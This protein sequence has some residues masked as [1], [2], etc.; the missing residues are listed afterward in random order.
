MTGY[1]ALKIIIIVVAIAIRYGIK[2]ARNSNPKPFVPPPP[3]SN[4]AQGGYQQPQNPSGSN[5]NPPSF[6]HN[7][8]HPPA[9]SPSSQSST[10]ADA[11]YCRFCGKKFS[12]VKALQ[13]DT[14][15]RHPD[16]SMLRK[17][18]LYTGPGKPNLAF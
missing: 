1:L 10:G 14:C 6:D 3:P 12:S 8:S 7:P 2:A 11:Y 18:E 15:F 16:T 5:Q 9:Y 13:M 17:H 4:P